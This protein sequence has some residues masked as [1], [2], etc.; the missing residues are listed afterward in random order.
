MNELLAFIMIPLSGI[1]LITILNVITLPR[2]QPAQPVRFPF[3]SVLIPARDEAE[4]I[5][6]T[7]RM[8]LEQDYPA[9]E[10]IILDDC[11]QDGTAGEARRASRGDPRLALLSGLPLPD[12]WLGKNWACHQLAQQATGDV[13][14]FTDADVRWGRG[15]LRAAIANFQTSRADMLAVLPTQETCTWGERLI[16]PLMALAI[17]GYLPIPAVHHIPWPSFAAANGQCLLF[18]RDAYQRLGGHKSVRTSIIED[19]SLARQAKRSGLRLRL[20]DGAGLV[21]NRM[22][23]NWIQVRDGFAKNILAGHGNLFFLAASTIFHWLLFVV[24]WL[25]LFVDWRRALPLVLLGVG[26]RCVSAAVTRQR[27]Q[28]GLLMPLSVFLI[29]LIALRSAIW[30]IRDGGPHW[31]GRIIKT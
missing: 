12:G 26:V 10:V 23:E 1:A 8:L 7:I 28:D 21:V 27:L 18:K 14:L 17:I 11:S 16:V 19:V 3:V 5:G 29:S 24:P 15:A 4:N 31:R 2:L 9:F 6:R 25:W 30:Y 22:Y 20:A 13:L